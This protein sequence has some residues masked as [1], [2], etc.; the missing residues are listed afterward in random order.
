MRREGEQTP[1]SVVHD[2]VYAKG[3]VAKGDKDENVDRLVAD[4][5]VYLRAMEELETPPFLRAVICAGV[6]IGGWR[7]WR[8]YRKKQLREAAQEDVEPGEPASSEEQ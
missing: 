7:V 3:R 5:D 4:R 6:R 1:A 8:R 2:V